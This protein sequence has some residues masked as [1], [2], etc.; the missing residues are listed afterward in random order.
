MPAQCIWFFDVLI[1][2]TQ[3]LAVSV[4]RGPGGMGELHVMRPAGDIAQ[5]DL[6]VPYEDAL[7]QW[8]ATMAPKPQPSAHTHT[9]GDGTT[10]TH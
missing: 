2:I 3:S 5:F 6:P 10:H 9:H 1:N 8:R 7:A 4:Q